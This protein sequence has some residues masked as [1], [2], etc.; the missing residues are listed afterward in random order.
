MPITLKDIADRTGVSPSVVSTVLSGRDN[1]TFV[2]KDTRE[3]VLRVAQ[4]LNYT[5]VRSGRPRGSR[6]LRRQRLDQF[7]GA[8]VPEP[9][10]LSAATLELLQQAVRQYSTMQLESEEFDYDFGLRLLLSD[11]LAR[12]DMLGVIGLII[13]GDSALPRT[14]AAANTPTVL[15]GEIDHAPQEIVTV[16]LDNFAAGRAIGDHLWRIGHRKVAF[17]APSS[18]PRVTRQRW[19]GLQSIWVEN[20]A[21]AD[22]CVP[23][24]YDTRTALDLKY[25]VSDTINEIYQ[26]QSESSRPTALVCFNEN[27]AAY[28]LQALF[29]IG[30]LVP[31]DVSLA[32]F[33]DTANGAEA[34]AVPLTT[35]RPP[36]KQLV[37]SAV[38]Q[39]YNIARENSAEDTTVSSQRS[40]LAFPGELIARESTRSVQP[41]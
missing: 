12:L 20:G 23:A 33:G 6:R 19:Q 26:K 14:A 8:W 38:A 24:P 37:T 36:M 28:A 29:A 2:S 25:Q 4:E 17:L 31:K 7:I 5:P 21:P 39:L 35:I 40:D 1:G 10:S 18:K 30:K 32:T 16:H 9:D 27:V 3:R 13:V 15:L 34:Q 22:G 11:D 41:V